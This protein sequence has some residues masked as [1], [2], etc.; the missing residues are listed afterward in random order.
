[1]VVQST[2]GQVTH[3]E[4]DRFRQ[5]TT[6]NG[7]SSNRVLCVAQ[8]VKGFLWVGTDEGVNRY[9]GRDFE[10]FFHDPTKRPISLSGNYVRGICAHG[11]L[12]FFAT[13]HG[14]SVFDVDLN[15]FRNE[16]LTD[17]RFN[18]KSKEL[19]NFI[20]PVGKNWYV[21]GETVLL[22]LNSDFSF[23]RDLKILLPESGIGVRDFTLPTVDEQGNIYFPS[24]GGLFYYD[25]SSKKMMSSN[26]PDAKLNLGFAH[27][28]HTAAPLL[29]DENKAM[30]F[31][32]SRNPRV[33]KRNEV[34]STVETTIFRANV[35]ASNRYVSF[36]HRLDEDIIWLCTGQGLIAFDPSSFSAHSLLLN[37]GNDPEPACYFTFTD[38]QKNAWIASETGLYQWSPER[39]EFH[40]LSLSERKDTEPENFEQV[41]GMLGE[42]WATTSGTENVVY[43]ITNS[44][45][46]PVSIPCLP[47]GGVRSIYFING[48]ELIVGGW[49]GICAYNIETKVC[50]DLDFIPAH[51]KDDYVISMSYDSHHNLWLS[52]GKGNGVL[53][54]NFNTR[55]ST[56]F[57]LDPI[58]EE[59]Q[60]HIPIANASDMVE[61]SLG[62]IW[63]V[64]S[65]QD[66]KVIKWNHL[67]DKFEELMP[68]NA[69]SDTMRF[70]GETY[71]VAF[72][73]GSIWFGVVREG[74][75]RYHIGS[76]KMEQFTR[77]DG[78]PS[79]LI[80]G[81]EFDKE[82]ILWIGTSNGLSA[83]ETES[84]V[85]TNFTV[86][87]GLPENSF[88]RGSFFDPEQ[89]R[90]YLNCNGKIVHFNPDRLKKVWP[91]PMIYLT[92]VMV[93]GQDVGV[94]SRKFSY[95]ENHIDFHFTA[96]DMIHAE[97][98]QYRYRLVG[99]EKE[100]NMAGFNKTASYANIPS[101]EYVFEVSVKVG[102]AWSAPTQLYSFHIPAIF[103]RTW[104]FACFLIGVFILAVYA[105]FRY[106]VE[107]Q[108]QL[109]AIRSR[110]SRDLHDDIGS[111]LSSIRILSAR[112]E[113]TD[114][115][116]AD[117]LSR[118]NRSSQT[119]LDT[120]DDI[121]WAINPQNDKGEQ[122]L[123]RMREFGSEL[124]EAKQIDYS[125]RFDE[126]LNDV[127][128]SLN[129]KRNVYLIFKEA[130]N[131]AAKHSG[132]K[133]VVIVFEMNRA[134]GLIRL[135]VSDN[136]VG[137]TDPGQTGRNGLMNMQKRA[138]EIGGT[139]T[140]NSEKG[141]GSELIL[142]FR[143]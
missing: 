55:T 39:N 46:V 63:M 89:N 93:E 126:H 86:T 103:Y 64:R 76:K 31:S 18:Y 108:K 34:R 62:N 35:D 36:S 136:G 52:F 21:G 3:Q 98:Y 77:L 95:S 140:V 23:S 116:M 12:M 37:A 80:Y 85:F 127:H 57:V 59:G 82:G 114:G 91:M 143:S 5:F 15:E 68:V 115:V 71:S 50:S 141:K 6:A 25:T 33:V 111:A 73:A 8:D 88:N 104:W 58:N 120:M 83:C 112:K 118:I 96:V 30:F 133:Q 97:A 131:N 56:H 125:M 138:D 42:I 69:N 129:Q 90:M 101:G 41:T 100:W 134:T 45:T 32:W 60:K 102:G 135:E 17:E 44:E 81:L 24:C 16:L 51:L 53:R 110:I 10:K 139:L 92:T 132:A 22:E 43:S 107:R 48:S 19:F 61:D 72:G 70:N 47:P 130:L 13:D 75:F 7:L 99:L 128:F 113:M 67:T 137:F 14:I 106:K 117:A 9:D 119:M 29:L 142:Q 38:A 54:Y 84:M 122:L 87:H 27:E 109:E 4:V 2:F 20:I 40:V 79:N 65:K 124:L 66:G 121:I 49:N 94:L 26:L 11:N 78:L 1:M 123:I 74:L 28:C 105:I